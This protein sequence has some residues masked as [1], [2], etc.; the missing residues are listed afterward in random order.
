MVSDITNNLK[1]A[2]ELLSTYGGTPT[3][4]LERLFLS[5]NGRYPYVEILGPYSEVETRMHNVADTKLEYII[6]YYLAY[7]DEDYA[8][9]SAITYVTRNVAGDIIKQVML[10]V[11][12]GSYAIKTSVVGHGNAFEAMEERV[13]FMIYVVLE[14]TARIDAKDPTYLG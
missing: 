11:S 6:K 8:N 9:V 13:E 14:I 12:R 5:I 7:N 1:N 4:E 10:D 2:L 3:V